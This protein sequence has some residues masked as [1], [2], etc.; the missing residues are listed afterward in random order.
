MT[1]DLS[2]SCDAVIRQA[3][4]TAKIVALYEEE[5]DR[6]RSLY[7]KSVEAVREAGLY[8]VMQPRRLG[9]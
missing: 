7:P 1:R 2:P 8:K 5:S 6:R 4:K 9:G 3:H